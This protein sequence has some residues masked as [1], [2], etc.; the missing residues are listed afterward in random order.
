MLQLFLLES[1]A[2]DCLMK[3]AGL[4][5]IFNAEDQLSHFVEIS[6]PVFEGFFLA[7]SST[8]KAIGLP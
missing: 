4:R 8:T 7:L 6:S 3:L 1:L 2:Y 5:L